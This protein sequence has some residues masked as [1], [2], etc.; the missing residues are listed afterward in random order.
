MRPGVYTVTFTLSGFTTLVRE[1]IEL[2]GSF[3]A[4]VNAELVI[5]SLEETITVSGESPAVDIR[6]VV[7]QEVLTDGVRELL[8]SAR[9]VQTMAQ[10]IPG[11]VS[12]GGARPSP[13]DVGGVTGERG[14]LM[15]H[16][17][18][19]QDFTIQMDGTPL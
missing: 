16:G 19:R 18:R 9:S 4:N 1:G 3:T 2:T 5:G 11:V 10:V 8:P 7:Q 12:I 13:Q 17:S 6:N 15:M 14:N